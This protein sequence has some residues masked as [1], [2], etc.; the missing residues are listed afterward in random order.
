[1]FSKNS[2]IDLYQTSHTL[3]TSNW[4]PSMNTLNFLP[5]PPLSATE[6][7]NFQQ[8]GGGL[9]RILAKCNNGLTGLLMFNRIFGILPSP[10]HTF[11]KKTC[12]IELNT[13]V[14]TGNSK[15]GNASTSFCF[16]QFPVLNF[17]AKTQDQQSVNHF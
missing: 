9:R 1:M 5:Q 8:A 4:S 10:V 7:G 14:E 2:E 11:F 3:S 17:I 16:F 6:T 13:D 15:L 12:I